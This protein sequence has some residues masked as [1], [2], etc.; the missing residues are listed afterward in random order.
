MKLR[1]LCLIAILILIAC[2]CLVSCSA[3]DPLYGIYTPDG[4]DPQYGSPY[5]ILSQERFNYIQDMAV[6]YQPG[7]KPARKGQKLIL[8]G[9]FAEE[10]Y[11]LV[12]RIRDE[13]TLVF[14]GNESRTVEI[15]RP[16]EDGTVFRM[17]EDQ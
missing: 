12:F 10:E 16:P 1:N 15:V 11:V 17:W 4:K 8:A 14:S 7:G 5:L 2:A 6:S 3:K 13:K 9:S